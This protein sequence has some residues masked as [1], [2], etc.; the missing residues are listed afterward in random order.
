M[1]KFFRKVRRKLLDEG[2]LKR[3]S[4]YAI[5]EILLVVI[6]ILLALQIN[7]WNE[8]RKKRNL[9]YELL[10]ELRATLTTDLS[11]EQRKTRGNK[12][13]I[14]SIQTIKSHIDNNLPFHDSLGSHFA[15]FHE[16]WGLTLRKDAYENIESHGL[17]FIKDDTIKLL[18]I[19]IYENE[20][21]N[22]RVYDELREY[23]NSVIVPIYND[24]FEFIPDWT[25][26]SVLPYDFEALQNDKRY[27]NML[28]TYLIKNKTVLR[29]QELQFSRMEEL[30]RR[31]LVEMNH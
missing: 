24:F 28:N 6:G 14:N 15:R 26:K 29:M 30:S 4:I 16:L 1:L 5:G 9:E 12:K 27:I 3:Y 18:L 25:S 17:R 11:T 8:D 22:N 10:S 7:N 19:A 2:N 13:V 31:L 23:R 20:Y 21:Y